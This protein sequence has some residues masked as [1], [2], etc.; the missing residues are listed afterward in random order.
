[1]SETFDLSTTHLHLGLGATAVPLD[2]FEWTPEY[3]AGYLERF[4][5]DGDEGRLVT[6]SDQAATWDMWERHP[7]GEEL[8]LLLSGRVDLVQDLGGEHHRIAL[9][10]GLA[11]V[12]PRNVWHTAEV[13]EPGRALFITPGRGTEHR[14]AADHPVE[15]G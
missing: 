5:A 6:V 2:D 10:P 8:V 13:H 4:A 7:A 14:S 9:S 3:L 1:M 11:A 15:A 12:N